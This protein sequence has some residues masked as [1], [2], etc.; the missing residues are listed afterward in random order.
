ML[1]R[2]LMRYFVKVRTNAPHQKLV[3]MD[4]SHFVASVHAAPDKGH[5]NEE[6][7][8]L[9]AEHFDCPLNAISIITGATSRKKFIEIIC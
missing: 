4:E 5:A 8:R 9:F 1:L 6:L 2:H 7:C 3:Q